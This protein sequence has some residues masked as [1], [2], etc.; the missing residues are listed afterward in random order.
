MR[1]I[2]NRVVRGCRDGRQ[3]VASPQFLIEET[4]ALRA[5][6]ERDPSVHFGDPGREVTWS[7]GDPSKP[8]FALRVDTRGSDDEIGILQ[9]GLKVADRVR[10]LRDFDAAQHLLLGVV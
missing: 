1:E 8:L 3:Q 5:E 10:G 4:E 9:C 6:K 7:D 2:E